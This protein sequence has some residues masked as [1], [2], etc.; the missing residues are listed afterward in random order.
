MLHRIYSVKK[1]RWYIFSFL[2]N[3]QGH[4]RWTRLGTEFFFSFTLSPE[5][6]PQPLPALIIFSLGCYSYM[7]KK[8]M[9]ACV[10]HC[11]CVL[12]CLRLRRLCLPGRAGLIQAV[13]LAQS[14]HLPLPPGSSL[15][16]NPT[17][18]SQPLVSPGREGRRKRQREIHSSHW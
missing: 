4:S 7:L 9:C 5:E 15:Q 3:A 12:G 13:V 11:L 1:K 6:I 10:H 17:W 16:P 18:A 2:T 8:R 14:L